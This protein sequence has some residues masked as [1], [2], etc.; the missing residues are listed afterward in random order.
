MAMLEKRTVLGLTA[1]GLLGVAGAAW[2]TAHA[3]AKREPASAEVRS[4]P[5]EVHAGTPARYSHAERRALLELARASLVDTVK[6]GRVPDLPDGL[7]DRLLAKKGC[8]VTLTV[9]GR[10]RGCIGHIFPQAPLAK[11]VIEN[12]RSAA[13]RDSRFAPVTEGE[14]AKIDIEVS[15]LSVPSPLAYGSPEDLLNKLRPGVDGVVL[16]IRGHRST[17]LPQVWEQLPD[18]VTFLSRLS[19]KAGQAPDAWRGLDT[20]VLVYQAEAFDESELAATDEK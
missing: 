5:T 2:W 20:R 6:R 15:V 1:V 10:L 9:H 14:L 16:D 18:A 8:F 3:T 19:A 17:F 11:A 4:T 13:I 12:A 7:S